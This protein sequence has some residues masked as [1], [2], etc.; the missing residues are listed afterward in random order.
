MSCNP[1]SGS[2]ACEMNSCVSH[3]DQLCRQE[4]EAGSVSRVYETNF[5][6][7]FVILVCEINSKASLWVSVKLTFYG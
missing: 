3:K 6:V 5:S 2:Q 4:S 7:G 1:G